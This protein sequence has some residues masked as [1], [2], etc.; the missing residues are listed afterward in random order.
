MN[1]GNL[2]VGLA[3]T[4]EMLA[5]LT[6]FFRRLLGPS[7]E[8]IGLIGG[9]WAR[10]WRVKNLLAISEKVDR[11]C[12]EKGI[13]PASGR[14]LSLAVGLPLLEKAS[15]QDDEFL[16]ERWAHLITSSVHSEEQA[17]SGFSLDITYIEILNQLSQLDCEVLEFIVENGIESREEKTGTM[18]GVQ[19]D[20]KWIRKEL[21][22]KLTHISLEKLVSLGCARLVLK[23]SLQADGGGGYGTWGQDIVVSLI[24]INM[25]MSASGKSPK[26]LRE[27]DG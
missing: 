3:T 23:A 1:D 20:P 17:E 19:L 16:Q 8:Q 22:N 7:V 6:G 26:W 14:R 15:F 18:K 12:L 13:D 25:Y 11:I 5:A 2:S 9:D 10:V 21:P 4:K 27:K 24:G